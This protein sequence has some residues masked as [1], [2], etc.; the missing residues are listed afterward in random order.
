MDL[1]I[2]QRVAVVTGGSGGIGAGIVR[3][4]ARE[5]ARV[6]VGYHT[7]RT[8]AEHL[9]Q[10]MDSGPEACMVFH[11]DLCAPQ[12]IQRAVEAV[13]ERWGR[14]DILVACA[15]QSAGWP[16]P[17]VLPESTSAEA[18]QVQLRANVEGSACVVQA[19]LPA[20]RAAGWGRI[21]LVSSGAAEDGAPGLEHYAAAKA[22]L[23]GIS[24]S[25][26][27]SVGP[28]GI[29]VNTVMP[30]FVATE[31]HRHSIPPQVFERIAAQTPT[32]RLATEEDVAQLVAFLVSD[33]NRAITGSE[34][35]V[36]GGMRM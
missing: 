31:R 32:R 35:R 18:W 1:G 13:L 24:R 3:C 5:G 23:H 6:A 19:V 9:V 4:L 15:W 11:D 29:L 33:A 20:M 17:D 25:L 26:A 14:V 2:H 16:Q 8:A 21:V 30:S 12:T 34:V 10:S 36:S 22:A 7:D 28:A 27:R